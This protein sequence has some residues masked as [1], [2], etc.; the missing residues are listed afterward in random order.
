MTHTLIGDA[1]RA[2]RNREIDSNELTA[3]ILASVTAR[4]G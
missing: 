1:E 3:A 4:H 2:R